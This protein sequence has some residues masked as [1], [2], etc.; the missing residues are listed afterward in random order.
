M[1]EKQKKSGD[2]FSQI[3]T[4][5]NVL[6]FIRVLL[7][8]VF[9]YLYST[10]TVEN[11]RM[12]W[13]VAVLFVSG[14]TDFLDGKIARRFNQ[15]SPLGKIFDPVA[16]KLTQI[17]IAIML[18][19]RFLHA[20]SSAMRAFSWVFL[21]FLLKELVMVVGGAVMLSKGIRPGAAEIF[22]KAATFVFYAVMLIIIAFGPEIGAVTMYYPDFVLPEAVVMILVVISALLTVGA[23]AS[24]MPETYRQFKEYWANNDKKNSK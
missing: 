20:E 4:I 7:I 16:D 19:F 5:P 11:K 10:A 2:L 14:L 8:P 24:Y 12:L 6:T 23:F 1:Q 21:I 18:F 9:A 3:W 17:T 22:G 15:V 13:A